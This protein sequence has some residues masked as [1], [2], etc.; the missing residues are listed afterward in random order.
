LL[1][2]GWS[3]AVLP[4][5]R[6][7]DQTFNSPWYQTCAVGLMNPKPNPIPNPSI[8]AT[9]GPFSGTACVVYNLLDGNAQYYIA[10][11]LPYTLSSTAT[12][13]Y[14]GMHDNGFSP[15]TVTLPAALPAKHYLQSGP[16]TPLTGSFQAG[17]VTGAGYYPNQLLLTI[18]TN[19]VTNQELFIFNPLNYGSKT[20][21]QAGIRDAIEVTANKD[22]SSYKVSLTYVETFTPTANMV[23]LSRLPHSKN[24][25]TTFTNNNLVVAAVGAGVVMVNES[26]IVQV[27]MTQCLRQL[28]KLNSNPANTD[29]VLALSPYC[30]VSTSAI[31]GKV[32]QGTYGANRAAPQ[33]GHI[34]KAYSSS[35]YMSSNN[36]FNK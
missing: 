25:Q 32:M 21:G 14:C 10:H 6:G 33:T 26:D 12:V 36:A 23:L 4:D 17:F 34:K 20:A 15:C 9:I 7:Y 27:D 19:G 2:I 1:L 30:V 18:V 11:S 5:E 31:R 29:D 13:R 22:G 16:Y 8:G 28:V 35:W 3:L 24:L